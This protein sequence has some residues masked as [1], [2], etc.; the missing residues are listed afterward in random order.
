M[1]E[2]RR[3][4][5]RAEETVSGAAFTP[6]QGQA[7]YDG[8]GNYVWREQPYPGEDG[9]PRYICA[10]Y[11]PDGEPVY[12]WAWWDQNGAAF[13]QYPGEAPFAL[14]PQ[15][16][17]FPVAVPDPARGKGMHFCFSF[18]GTIAAATL[19]TSIIG[20][21]AQKLEENYYWY[22]I[23]TTLMIGLGVLLLAVAITMRVV[24]DKKNR[25]LA[26]GFLW[27]GIVVVALP[28]LVGLLALLIVLLIM[29]GV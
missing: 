11:S 8:A 24:L 15:P 3:E 16:G 17:N 12:G 18:F 2:I 22:G 28:F 27:G 20:V 10:R 5:E 1:E 25:M 7:Q 26:R 13:Y 4:T 21:L 19:L 14:A 6:P 9:Q 29:C 23:G